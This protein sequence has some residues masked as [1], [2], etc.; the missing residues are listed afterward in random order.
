[1]FQVVRLYTNLEWEIQ[2]REYMR[3][4]I[5]VAL[6]SSPLGISPATCR[7]P[8]H[9]RT[10]DHPWRESQTVASYMTLFCR[11][12]AL[13]WVSLGAKAR[14]KSSQAELHCMKG[15]DAV[16]WSWGSQIRSKERS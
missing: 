15:G 8:R 3:Y 9:S 16:H 5:R 2:V 14:L 13:F 10:P 4:E 1:M 12:H 11:V 7:S 6:G